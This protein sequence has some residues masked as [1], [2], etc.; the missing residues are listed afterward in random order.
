MLADP[1]EVRCDERYPDTRL[2]V[3]R[4]VEE[5]G[6]RNVVVVVITGEPP[7]TRHW[8]VT[9]FTSPRSPKGDIEWKRP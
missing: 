7:D 8:I 2:F 6:G 4:S 3:R 9:A 1:D 5:A